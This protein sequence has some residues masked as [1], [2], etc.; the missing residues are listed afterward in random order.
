MESREKALDKRALLP[1]ISFSL[2]LLEFA[3]RGG[4]CMPTDALN[5]RTNFLQGGMMLTD[6]LLINASYQVLTRVNWQRAVTM[7]VTGEAEIFEFASGTAIRSQFLELPMPTIIRMRNYVH[8]RYPDLVK[9]EAASRARILARD[10]WTCVYG[11]GRGT[12][13]DHVIPQSRGGLNTWDN[14][15]ACCGPCNNLKGD[16]TPIE[17]GIRLLW[18]PR[19]PSR[20]EADQERV[21][22]VLASA[23]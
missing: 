10:K 21:W 12:T 22:Q 4:F 16:R 13:I 20:S 11:G 6:V 14:L 5:S 8:V 1:V 9:S 18:I 15:A 19:A 2:Q 3:R 23:A 17:A 7:V